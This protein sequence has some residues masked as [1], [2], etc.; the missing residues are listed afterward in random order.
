M[1]DAA[2]SREDSSPSSYGV[3]IHAGDMFFNDIFRT[4]T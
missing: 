4:D 3:E 2:A 1:A